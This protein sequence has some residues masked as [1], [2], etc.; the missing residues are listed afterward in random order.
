MSRITHNALAAF[1]GLSF[2]SSTFANDTT[3]EL[4]TGG[5]VLTRT[6]DVEMA[7]EDLFISPSKVEVDYVFHNTTDHD[8][9]TL[10]AF[11][12]PDMTGD[13]EPGVVYGNGDDETWMQ[14]ENWLHFA[15]SQDG[16]DVKPQIQ[17]R[18]S[19][20]G[21]DMT[22]QL[23]RY[24]IPKLPFADATRE[25][26]KTLPAEVKADWQ[27]RGLI[28]VD[29]PGEAAEEITPYWTLSTTY[30]WKTTFPANKDVKVHHSYRP[31]VG[32][33]N[34]LYF[35]NEDGEAKGP[36][37]DD[38]VKR[39]CIDDS[40]VKIAKSNNANMEAGKPYYDQRWISYI[41]TTGGNWSGGTIKD[42]H[43]TVDKGEKTSILSLCADGIK[44]TGP[45]T[46]ELRKTD[47]NPTRDINILLLVKEAPLA[48]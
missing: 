45:T 11:P 16:V 15:A 10:V 7:K 43:L 5:L 19:V 26:L 30:F 48:Q 41:L 27:N 1:L 29:S 42:F 25:A 40:I 38:Y 36:D 39:Y 32:V 6:G 17:Q 47:F 21:V 34:A 46:F 28:Y 18:V 14:T 37:Y 44:K 3:A 23:D 31:S 9:D 13:I 8:V 4:A 35:L 20:A 24:K 22:D 2:A 12:M 33:Q